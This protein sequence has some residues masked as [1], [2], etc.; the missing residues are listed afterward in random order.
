MIDSPCCC[1]QCATSRRCDAAAELLS[2][3]S[4]CTRSTGVACLAAAAAAC[5][6]DAHA[7]Q[8]RG[9]ARQQR[10]PGGFLSPAHLPLDHLLFLLSSLLLLAAPS[11]LIPAVKLGLLG[12]LGLPG[13]EQGFRGYR[14]TLCFRLRLLR[15][16]QCSRGNSNPIQA[17]TAGLALARHAAQA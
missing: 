13:L 2:N 14:E 7:H 3:F 4:R 9:A 8:H 12:L 16:S 1:S 15:P 11:T 6:C 5:S 10:T 17:V